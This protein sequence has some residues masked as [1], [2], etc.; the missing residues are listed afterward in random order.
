M[1]NVTYHIFTCDLHFFLL[2]IRFTAEYYI[3]N[4]RIVWFD[5]ACVRT[6]KEAILISI[7]IKSEE[8]LHLILNY[9]SQ[10]R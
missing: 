1:K 2:V 3:N 7:I 6:K 4:Y 5:K 8:T 10:I 9:E